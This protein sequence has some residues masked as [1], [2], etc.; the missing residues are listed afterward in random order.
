MRVVVPGEKLFDSPKQMYGA[1]VED[2]KTYSSR[3]ALFH[4]DTQKIV[5]LK[6]S[7][8]PSM[9]DGVI[10]VVEEVK[11][12]GYVVDVNCAYKGFL[13]ARDVMRQLRLGDVIDAIVKEV[14]EVRNINL[15]RP[16]TLLGGEIL[17]VSPVK[18]PRVIGKKNSMIDMIKN[19]TKSA[20]VVGKNGRVWVKGGNAAVAVAAILKVER[21][22]HTTG[23]TDRIAE[24]LKK[25]CG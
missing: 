14:D 12:S 5:P 23:L 19:A 18:I 4:E 25:E 11:F 15:I 21:E 24:F 9:E 13:S 20:I 10:G 6:G 17:E 3:L 2:G 1:Y 7:Y 8:M 22:A 16:R